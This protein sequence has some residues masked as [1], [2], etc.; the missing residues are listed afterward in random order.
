MREHVDKSIKWLSVYELTRRLTRQTPEGFSKNITNALRDLYTNPPY[1]NMVCKY[2]QERFGLN[3]NYL[4]LFANKYGFKIKCKDKRTE[5]WITS[6]QL[7]TLIYGMTPPQMN[8]LLQKYQN[9]MPEW[10]KTKISYQLPCLCLH[11]DHLAEF[12][13]IAKLKMCESMTK[14]PDWLTLGECRLYLKDFDENTQMDSLA[15]MF[16][17]QSKIHPDWIQ[18]KMTKSGKQVLCLNKKYLPQFCAATGFVCNNAKTEQWLN[19]KELCNLLNMSP[20]KILDILQKHKDAY[21]DIIKTKCKYNYSYLCL[22]S[23]CVDM[24]CKWKEQLNKTTNMLELLQYQLYAN[25]KLR[26]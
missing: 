11:R 19:A 10:I 7:C 2:S 15:F 20:A 25:N 3:P 1:S 21:P 14:T 12:C 26:Q 16:K 4:E 13:Q 18:Y 22:R 6:T 8:N 17:T 9:K 24:V 5:D 23:D